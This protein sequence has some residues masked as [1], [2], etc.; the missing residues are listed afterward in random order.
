MEGCSALFLSRKDKKAKL[1]YI[2]G[3]YDKNHDGFLNL[4]E[5]N[6]GFK[7]LYLMLGNDNCDAL[8]KQM[9]TDTL[10]KMGSTKSKIK[11]GK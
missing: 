6:D 3:L 7:A 11:K 5:I 4:Q 8:S 10:N 1:D 9:A 2:F